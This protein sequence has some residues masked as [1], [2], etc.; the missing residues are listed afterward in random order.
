MCV[1]ERAHIDLVGKQRKWLSTNEFSEIFALLPLHNL[2]V[3]R[4]VGRS[5]VAKWGKGC[6]AKNSGK[7]GFE[8]R[9]NQ[10]K[11]E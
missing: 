1:C 3:E 2:S 6:S 5:T 11:C 8:L 7:A 10:I 4:I 9:V